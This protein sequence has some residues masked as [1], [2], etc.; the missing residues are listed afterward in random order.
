MQALRQ[1]QKQLVVA[2]AG[3]GATPDGLGEGLLA[4]LVHLKDRREAR[5]SSS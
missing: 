1:E 4:A 3:K 2:L 5:G